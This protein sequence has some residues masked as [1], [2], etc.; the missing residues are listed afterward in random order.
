VLSL[1]L[2]ENGLDYN[3]MLLLVNNKNLLLLGKPWLVLK[4]AVSKEQ[5]S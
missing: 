5:A 2:S 3:L 4:F 1:R